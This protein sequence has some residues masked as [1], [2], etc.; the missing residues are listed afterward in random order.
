MEFLIAVFF[1]TG[2]VETYTSVATNI[3]ETTE[4][5]TVTT[6]VTSPSSK[7]TTTVSH[8]LTTSIGI[9]SM[10]NFLNMNEVC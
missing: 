10:L 9:K 1:I 5:S 8:A 7:V 3:A 2:P 4:K 6:S